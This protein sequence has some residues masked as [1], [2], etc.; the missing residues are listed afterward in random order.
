MQLLT[1]GQ[2]WSKSWVG[3]ARQHWGPDP[4]EEGRGQGWSRGEVRE[5]RSGGA[6]RRGGAEG[7]GGRKYYKLNF[8]F[9]AGV[10]LL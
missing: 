7:R 8:L 10:F 1:Q 9:L 5:G 6:E 3:T 2:W 4:A